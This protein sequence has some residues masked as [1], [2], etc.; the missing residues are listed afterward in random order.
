[1]KARRVYMFMFL[2]LCGAALIYVWREDTVVIKQYRSLDQ[3]LQMR[4]DYSGT[5][6]PPNI[7]PLNFQV[8]ASGE[9]Y[10][11]RIYARRGP[12]IKIFSRS[13]NIVIPARPWRELLSQNRSEDLHY[14]IFVQAQDGT[15]SLF[16]TLTNRIGPEAID[17]FLVYR[18]MH[19]THYLV[20]GEVGL[21]QRDLRNYNETLI[22]KNKHYKHGGCVNCHS[23][24]SN[25]PDKTLIAVRSAPYGSCTLLINRNQ[26]KKIGSKFT[27]AAWHPSGK[28]ASFSIN[29][30]RQ[31]MHAARNE[32]REAV[33]IDS[34]M[35]YYLADSQTVK[36]SAQISKK[37]RLE[38]YPTWAPNG[39]FLY[40]CSAPKQWFSPKEEPTIESS[41]RIK[42]DLVRIGYN[43]ELDTWGELETVLGAEQTNKSALLPR[44]SPDGR[45][46]LLCMTDYG[47]IPAFQA[48]S[49]LYLIDLQAA[50]QTGRPIARPLDINSDQSESWHSWAGNS[51]WIAFS[52]KRRD[53]VF[54]RVYLSYVDSAGKVYKPLLLPQK[55]PTFFDHCL[56]AF[57]TPEL[58]TQAVR[59]VGEKLARVVRSSSHI[60]VD[61][62]ITMATPNVTKQVPLWQQ[63]E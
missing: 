33:D 39:R 19:P 8:C 21:Y 22:L 25:S 36:T 51:R 7:A 60:A 30:V 20:S 26:V 63:R 50:E 34:T 55:D 44:I 45:W 58:V 24:C 13:P 49:D 4:P 5:V 40:F 3:P 61:M 38:T 52:S 10:C 31:L 41:P 16:P 35:V 54:T 27:Y 2:L 47:S 56:E 14:D 9:R 59:P 12:T 46:L 53:G 11:V 6:I 37:E 29:N 28:L 23:F 42:Y 15:W 32:V 43:L 1:M 57:N 62:P 18:R 48:E 17:P